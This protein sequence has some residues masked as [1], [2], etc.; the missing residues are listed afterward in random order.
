MSRILIIEDEKLLRD[1][2]ALLLTSVGHQV[3]LAENGKVGLEKVKQTPPNLIILD[4][5][6]PVM[7]GLQFLKAADN[8]QDFSKINLI[9]LS[10]L[11]DPVQPKYMQK[12]K[13]TKPLLKSELSPV[14]LVKVVDEALGLGKF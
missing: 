10:N 14:E 9:I 5:L 7:D 12:F 6:M 8:I 13:L 11:S 1:A 2:F 3:E 4:M